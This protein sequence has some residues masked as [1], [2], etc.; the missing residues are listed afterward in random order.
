MPM[1]KSVKPPIKI[2]HAEVILSPPSS[3]KR[4][5]PGFLKDR[6]L[7]LNQFH[8]VVVTFS[9]WLALG[10]P[11]WGT[12]WAGVREQHSHPQACVLSAN[13]LLL[14]SLPLRRNRVL[15]SQCPCLFRRARN[16]S[17]IQEKVFRLY[18][19]RCQGYKKRNS[20]VYSWAIVKLNSAVAVL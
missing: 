7:L 19:S 10:Q 17:K 11:L 16:K 9:R 20:D 14:I 1:H 2:I 5:I 13:W 3:K 6:F 12:S 18:S 8:P 15:E 4:E